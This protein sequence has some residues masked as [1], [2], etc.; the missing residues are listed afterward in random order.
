MTLPLGYYDLHNL[1]FQYDPF[2]HLNASDDPHLFDYLVPPRDVAIA[3]EDVHALV[4]APGGGG[5]TA[6]RQYAENNCLNQTWELKFPVTYV[7]GSFNVQGENTPN[8]VLKQHLN[9]I[10]AAINTDILRHFLWKPGRFLQLPKEPQLDFLK[11]FDTYITS[12]NFSI[13]LEILRD[14][15][16]PREAANKIDRPLAPYT[17]PSVGEIKELH[18]VLSE[19]LSKVDALPAPKLEDLFAL[20]LD[21]LEARSIYVYID[22]VD[23][24]PETIHNPER[25]AHWISPLI[26]K[27]ADLSHQHVYLKFFLPIEVEIHL[28]PARR[29]FPSVTLNWNEDFLMDILES[30]VR[31]ASKQQFTSLDAISNPN[32]RGVEQMIVDKINDKLPREALR[33]TKNILEEALKH[34]DSTKFIT[35][36]DIENAYR[37]YDYQYLLRTKKHT[38]EMD[39]KYE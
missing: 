5:K 34:W 30:R 2:A 6:L 12:P 10:R 13:L 27:G 22:G 8:A 23:A 9:Q 11:S 26:E 28:R 21:Y 7:P 15:Y 31:A 1:G 3:W 16:S 35:P 39:G 33:L 18:A 24:F 36:N 19:N 14:N 20:T 29:N 37:Y 25:A 17:Q 32:L 4:F 38:P